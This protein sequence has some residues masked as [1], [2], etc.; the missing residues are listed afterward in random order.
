MVLRNVPVDYISP[1]KGLRNINQGLFH[2][3]ITA[4]CW[5]FFHGCW[6][7]SETAGCGSLF[8]YGDMGR[9]PGGMVDLKRCTPAL[10]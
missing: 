4:G 9:L 5:H 1:S 8:H 3:G 7:Y 10:G 2:F 6:H